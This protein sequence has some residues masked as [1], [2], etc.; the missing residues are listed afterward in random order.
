M[1]T[2]GLLYRLVLSVALAGLAG[3]SSVSQRVE[4]QRP[5]FQPEYDLTS[6]G[7]KTLF[8]RL[9]ELD[10]GGLHV[11]VA[12]DYERNAPLRIAV[13]P[14]TDRGSAN[15]VVDKIPLTFRNRQQRAIWAWTDAQRLRRSMLGYLA[16]REF[17]ILNPI[18]IDAVLQSHGIT[19]EASL[20]RIAPQKLSLLAPGVDAVVY[21][22]VVHYEAYY[23]AL[24]SGWQVSVRGGMVS[25]HN[26]EPLVSFYGSRYDINFSPALDPQDIL[27]NSAESLLQLRDIELARSEQ[28]VCREL[29]LRIPVSEN[30]RLQIAREA[31]E[32]DLRAENSAMPVSMT[33]AQR[34]ASPTS[35]PV[36]VETPP[37]DE[38]AYAD[39]VPTQPENGV[40]IRAAGP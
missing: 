10:P 26:G 27:I 13:L 3:C 33:T 11:K 18:G 28:E 29:V 21:G 35:R 32:T 17:Y 14:F 30:L 20:E 7:R 19:D 40:E 23:L 34:E 9:V 8:D 6:H 16:G 39:S 36:R 1:V 4:E 37:H 12:S 22:E 24:L 2:R 15:F 25:T 5:F 31:L 38:S